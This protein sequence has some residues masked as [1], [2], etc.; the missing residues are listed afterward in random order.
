MTRTDQAGHGRTFTF[1]ELLVV[2]AILGLLL[3]ILL[4]ALAR[5][6]DL[7]DRSASLATMKQIMVGFSLYSGENNFRLP[8]F[9]EPGVPAADLVINGARLRTAG[10]ALN[11]RYQSWYSASAT[12][13]YL[14]TTTIEL[15]DGP[16]FTDH[17]VLLDPPAEPGRL[18][19]SRY[20]MSYTAFGAPEFFAD[21]T[22]FDYRH[23]RGVSMTEVRHPARKGLLL[24]VFFP[25]HTVGSPNPPKVVLVAF[26]DGHVSTEPW[27]VRSFSS[28][29]PPPL[30]V[31]TQWPIMGTKDGM[32]GIDY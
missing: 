20:Q 30:E 26:V 6:R 12:V 9:G 22:T 16:V 3:A 14:S 18:L 19:T 27:I 24:D 11:L 8:Y 28:R 4:P 13:S 25:G 5:T 23:L 32:K 21:D 17:G 10:G 1:I 7:R 31:V 2:L 29:T 15:A